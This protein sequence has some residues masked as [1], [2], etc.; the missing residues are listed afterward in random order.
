MGVLCLWVCKA[1]KKISILLTALLKCPIL[2]Q[3][4][5]GDFDATARSDPTAFPSPFR[6]SEIGES[7]AERTD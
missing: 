3:R 1:R 6:E 5:N 7:D 4:E 2:P